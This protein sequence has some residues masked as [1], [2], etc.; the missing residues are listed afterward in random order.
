M[1]GLLPLKKGAFIEL[2]HV[3]SI[4]E[5]LFKCKETERYY[6]QYNYPS[7]RYI[8]ESQS[9]FGEYI[10]DIGKCYNKD[11]KILCYKKLETMEFDQNFLSLVGTSPLGYHHPDMKNIDFILYNIVKTP[12]SESDDLKYIVLNEELPNNPQD[13][14]YL[15]DGNG[16]W[17]FLAKRDLGTLIEFEDHFKRV[18][19]YKQDDNERL[20]IEIE[21][22]KNSWE[23]MR[24]KPNINVFS[25]KRLKRREIKLKQISP[26]VTN[27]IDKYE[28]VQ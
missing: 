13:H 10:L 1:S 12:L 28:K 15:K 20:L 24:K 19:E 23:Y 26:N 6:N 9:N 8:L 16:N 2:S 18:W 3:D 22:L 5:H 17:Y 4:E 11:I 14:G 27:R 21:A 25:G 7:F